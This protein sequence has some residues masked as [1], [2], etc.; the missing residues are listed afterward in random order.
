MNLQKHSG[1][2]RFEY[3][4]ISYGFPGNKT[5]DKELISKMYKKLMQLN[6]RKMNNPIQKWAK[7]LN[8]HRSKEDTQTANKHMKRYSVLLIIRECKSKPQ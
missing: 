4:C 2:F 8:G 6:A 3:T 5:T 7:E 1:V